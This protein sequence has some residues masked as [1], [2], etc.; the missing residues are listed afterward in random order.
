MTQATTYATS[1]ARRGR[2]RRGVTSMLAMMF[3]VLFGALAVGF[4]A[5]INTSVQIATNQQHST[6]ALLAAESGL[7]FMRYQLANVALSPDTGPEAVMDELYTKL[8]AQLEGTANFKGLTVSFAGDVIAIPAEPNGWVPLDTEAGAGFRAAIVRSGGD[9]SCRVAGRAAP[10]SFN[11]TPSGRTIKVDFVRA[12][13]ATSIFDYAVA[14]KGRI[15][16]IA[17]TLSGV[18]GF[19]QNSIA[20]II[21]ARETSPAISIS[22][23]FIGGD[24]S[25]TSPELVSVTGGSVG[26]SS[27]VSEIL[28]DHTKLVDKPLFPTFDAS[29]FKQYAT[30]TYTG[31]SVLKNVRIPANTNPTFAGGAIIQGVVYVES[32][33]KLNFRGNTIIQG[34]IVIEDKGTPGQNQ[35]DMRGSFNQFPFP[36]GAEYDHL[37]D[38]SGISIFAPTTSMFVSGSVNSTLIGNVVVN[39][40]KNGG[41]ADLIVDKGTLITL[42]EGNASAVFDG[43]SVKFK[44]VGKNFKPSKGVKFDKRYIPRPETYQELY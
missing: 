24:I 12:D 16:M 32:P 27:S 36:S 31:G 39:N 34:I 9:I 18:S 42:D 14:S 10:N 13:Q 3:L 23:G 29:V 15:S 6:K 20:S 30:A 40:F 44:S 38:I 37:R 8:K 17:G 28:N 43:K 1:H 7:H 21:A 33:N 22:G 26:G 35:I 25:V 19:S 41:S 2:R 4:Y 11:V 5:S